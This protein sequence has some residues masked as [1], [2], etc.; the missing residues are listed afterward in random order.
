MTKFLLLPLFTAKNTNAITP[1][2]ESDLFFAENDRPNKKIL[3]N[4]T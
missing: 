4:Q 1:I 3:L 2:A